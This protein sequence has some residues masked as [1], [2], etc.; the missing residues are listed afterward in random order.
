MEKLIYDVANKFATDI[1]DIV[2]PDK[3]SEEIIKVVE[4]YGKNSKPHIST[5]LIKYFSECKSIEKK[6]LKK[7]KSNLQDKA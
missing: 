3:F 7:L 5:I 1:N 2:S 6:A 4:K